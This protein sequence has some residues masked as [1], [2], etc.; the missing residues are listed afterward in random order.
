MNA[1]EKKVLA[2]LVARDDGVVRGYY[3]IWHE[4]KLWLVT[5]WIVDKQTGVGTP[6]RMI[7]VDV[8]RATPGGDD[9]PWDFENVQL[10]KAVIEGISQDAP[11]YEIRSLPSS[12]TVHRHD[13]KPLPPLFS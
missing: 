4:E 3:G 13:L 6:E 8:I 2:L 9:S 7:R 12:P 5:A 10:P 11:G 1:P